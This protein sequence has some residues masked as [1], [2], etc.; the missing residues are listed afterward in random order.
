MRGEGK[1]RERGSEREK[2]PEKI[3]CP[4][5]FY[6]MRKWE[7]NE[8]KIEVVRERE[9]EREGGE[10]RKETDTKEEERDGEIEKRNEKGRERERKRGRKGGRETKDIEKNHSEKDQLSK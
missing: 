6:Y 7:R 1:K 9:K 3:N 10:K 8:R 5:S 2:H 4:N